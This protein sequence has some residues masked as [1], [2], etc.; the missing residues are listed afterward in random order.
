MKLQLSIVFLCLFTVVLA[1]FPQADERFFSNYNY[2]YITESEGAPHSFVDDIVRDSDGFVWMATHNGI[3]RYDGYQVLSFN[4]QTEPLKLKNDFVHKLCEDNF[5]RLWIASEGG[6]ELLDLDTYSVI[7]PFS[8]MNDT[9]R[10]LS[11]G[12]VHSLYKDKKGNLWVS[13]SNNLWCVELDE[14]G[15]INNYYIFLHN[16]FRLHIFCW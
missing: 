13:C 15:G 9:L 11:D 12:Y 6:L 8:S 7:D 2:Y 5:R 1:A 3:G 14:K 10:Q 16:I 4:T